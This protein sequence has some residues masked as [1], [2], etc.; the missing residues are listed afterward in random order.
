MTSERRVISFGPFFLKKKRIS[1]LFVYYLHST[2]MAVFVMCICKLERQTDEENSPVVFFSFFNELNQQQKKRL[3][4]HLQK[5]NLNEFLF[6]ISFNLY[7]VW[8]D[9]WL[10]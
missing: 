6:L 7:V 2:K 4:Q 8:G 9:V 5:K 1:F 3:Q 10:F